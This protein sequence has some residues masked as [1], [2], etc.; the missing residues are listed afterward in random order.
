LLFLFMLINQIRI[1]TK[2]TPVAALAS[3]ALLCLTACAP[4][5]KQVAPPIEP[6]IPHAHDRTRFDSG[7]PPVPYGNTDWQAVT[8]ALGGGKKIAS[9]IGRQASGYG[10]TMWASTGGKMV[11]IAAGRIVNNPPGVMS[12]CGYAWPAHGKISR[13]FRP[14]DNHK[15]LDITAE[16]G[17]PIHAAR[18][19]KVIYASNEL[20]GF[21]NC[22]IIQHEGEWTTFYAHNNQNF[23]QP[24]DVVQCGQLIAEV[25]KTG[26]ATGPHLH[27]EI[28]QNGVALD[29]HPML[30]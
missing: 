24:G 17:V 20:S 30:P 6:P 13:G 19:G 23:V 12:S 9:T 28:R 21:G 10:K 2:V 15:G 25:G 29:P 5:K 11:D 4:Q 16:I 8:A 27:F 3:I 14:Q 18:A 7:H 26:R 1:T 22:I